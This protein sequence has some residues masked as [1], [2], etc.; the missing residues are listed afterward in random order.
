MGG[1]WLKDLDFPVVGKIMGTLAAKLIEKGLLSP[2]IT[3]SVSLFEDK[4][5]ADQFVA[6]ITAGKK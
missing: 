5:R 4:K 1:D 3:D 6:A 2:K